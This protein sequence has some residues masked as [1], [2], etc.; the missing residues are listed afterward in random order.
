[1]PRVDW[2][3]LLSELTD[4]LKTELAD[5]V[6]GAAD[7]L[8]ADGFATDLAELM[9]DAIKSGDEKLIAEAKANI[10]FLLETHR[11]R[12]AHAT[13]ATIEK[14]LSV[15]TRMATA[16]LSA[17]LGGLGGISAAAADGG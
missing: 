7:D 13:N 2:N 14:V 15:A 4:T 3:G 9:L 5:L 17:V 16:G 11:L 10:P 1:M 8:A 6:E 12:A